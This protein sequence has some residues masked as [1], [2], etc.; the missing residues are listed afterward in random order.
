MMIKMMSISRIYNI[1]IIIYKYSSSFV[2]INSNKLLTNSLI[3]RKM[4]RGKHYE[5]NKK[6]REKKKE[7][8][9]S[10]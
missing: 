9:L 6:R 5:K 8:L 2:L 7:K 3:K 10:K 4:E 1:Y